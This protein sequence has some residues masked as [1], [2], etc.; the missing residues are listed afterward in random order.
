MEET[1]CAGGGQ[2]NGDGISERERAAMALETS[3]VGGACRLPR[4]VERVGDEKTGAGLV[5][6][7][8]AVS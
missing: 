1:R 3:D 4:V 8:E 5:L 6:P 7:R 2:G